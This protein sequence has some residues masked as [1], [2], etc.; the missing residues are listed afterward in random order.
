V[1]TLKTALLFGV[2][3][4]ILVVGG[5]ALF[6]SRG[7]VIGLVIAL[8]VNGGSYWFSDRIAL[9]SMRARPVSEAEQPAMYAIVRELSTAAHQPMPRLYISPV[10]QPNAFATGRNPKH[11]AVCATEGI[12]QILD[13]REMRAVLGHELSHVYNRDI[14]LSSVAGALASCI[15]Y[16]AQ[17]AVFFGG[18]GNDRDRNPAAEL[19]MLFLGPLAAALIQLAISR[20]RE[21]QADESGAIL[22]HDPLALASA[23][24]KLQ[25][26]VTARPLPQQPGL[27]TTSQLMIANPFRPSG[28]G[29]L[30]A[31][32][33]P[34]DKRIARLETMAKQDP[35]YWQ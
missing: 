23:L 25:A 21:Y 18:G 17:F 30:F 28:I 26:G 3:G 12:L 34:M 2:L 22:A 19:L 1:N 29:N 4:A 7:L 20:S 35:S 32:H 11:A 8:A 15:T 14:L 9:A 16:L 6:G 31:T 24:R 5:G 27:L 33:P 13:R 10:A